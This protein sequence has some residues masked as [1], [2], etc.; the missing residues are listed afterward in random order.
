MN[1]KQL[2]R[3]SLTTLVRALLLGSGLISPGVAPPES[4]AREPE[5]TPAPTPAPL[6]YF[7]PLDQ[8]LA[9]RWAEA[10]VKPALLSSDAEFIRRLFLDLAGRI[11]SILEV[12]DFID[13]PDP[14]KRQIWIDK[15]LKEPTYARH[16]ANVWRAILLSQTNAQQVGNLAPQLEAWLYRRLEKNVAYDKIVRE[17][18][19]K[20]STGEGQIIHGHLLPTSGEDEGPQAFLQAQEYRPENLAGAT[21]RLFMGVKLECAQCHSH[22]F[23]RWTRTQFW[24]LAAF[25]AQPSGPKGP[26]ANL[27]EL[28]IP[29][30]DQ[31]VSPRFPDGSAPSWR[32]GVSPQ[33]AL[34]EW[35][36]SPG[37]PYFARAT[38]NRVWGYFFGIGLIDPVDDAGEHNSPSHPELLDE[39]AQQFAASGFDL[40]QLIRKIVSS[41]AY[42][43]TSMASQ[44]SQD[45]PR[46]FAR[47]IVRGLSPE[48][49]IDSIDLAAEHPWP[50]L[51]IRFTALPSTNEPPWGQFRAHFPPHDRASEVP[52]TILQALFMMNSKFMADLT[53]PER[54]KT[55]ATIAASEVSTTRKIETIYLVVLARKPRPE[56]ADRLI[57]Y[58]D[59]G[60]PSGDRTAALGDVFWVLL[61]SAEF[62]LNH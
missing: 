9:G 45:D 54:N 55:L 24:E 48:Q 42:Q 17:L 4:P 31:V 5:L 19:T 35:L 60:G 25:F 1:R 39:L 8:F 32:P 50:E 62:M 13:D 18:L 36:T 22:P 40:K 57:A 37:N 56:E 34:A 51:A 2:A 15:L 27:R 59:R 43:M 14:D 6:P 49:L 20:R 58:V 23:A 21:A 46:L 53:N 16:F 10:E 11:P 33:E 41:Y 26:D 38:V 47:K 52:T 3:T 44:S 7:T 28:T 30:T 29:G 61:N 12:R